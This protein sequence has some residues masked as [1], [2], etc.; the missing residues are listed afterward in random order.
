MIE[1]KSKYYYRCFINSY[2]VCA[3]SWN[4][5]LVLVMEKVNSSQKIHNHYSSQNS[6]FATVYNSSFA[7]MEIWSFIEPQIYTGLLLSFLIL[8]FLQNKWIINPWS[9]VL[10][11]WQNQVLPILMISTGMYIYIIFLY[12]MSVLESGEF[13]NSKLMGVCQAGFAISTIHIP[14]T[15]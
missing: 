9:L 14:R 12:I 10:Q 11:M 5:I 7:F 1:L 6:F 2:N 3:R 8:F 15:A 4:E 13:S